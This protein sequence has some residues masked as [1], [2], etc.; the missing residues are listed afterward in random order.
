MKNNQY[1]RKENSYSRPII[2]LLNTEVQFLRGCYYKSLKV[3][4]QIHTDSISF[5]Y[6]YFK[7]LVRVY[8]DLRKQV[9][10]LLAISKT[11]QKD[12]FSNSTALPFF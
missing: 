7:S 12:T 6:G 9:K 11:C 10:V 1:R 4:H 8:G 2:V 5:I 3:E